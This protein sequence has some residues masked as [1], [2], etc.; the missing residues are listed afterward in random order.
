MANQR[1]GCPEIRLRRV[2]TEDLPGVVDAAHWDPVLVLDSIYDT[3][4][5]LIPIAPIPRHGQ[6]SDASLSWRHID[7][8]P[9]SAWPSA[10]LLARGGLSP[11]RPDDFHADARGAGARPGVG[12]AP[13]TDKEIRS[14][15][16]IELD[17]ATWVES[18]H[19]HIPDHVVKRLPH[20]S[21]DPLLRGLLAA[22]DQRHEF[23]VVVGETD[24][25]EPAAVTDTSAP[26]RLARGRIHIAL[27]DVPKEFV[28]NLAGLGVLWSVGAIPGPREVVAAVSSV[29]AV[30][31]FKTF[32]RLTADE[33]H[34]ANL[35]AEKASSGLSTTPVELEGIAGAD[36]L[37]LLAKLETDGIA[38][39]DNGCWKI[40]F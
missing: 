31:F 21:R 4:D 16:T 37:E 9:P 10:A 12:V 20:I 15:E 1:G 8:A 11:R 27:S 19:L 18:P 34:M 23:T 6:F 25:G 24:A 17:V 39:L 30:A 35:V 3:P 28:A 40:V 36:A 7:D 14:M 22:L 13:V 2:T 5:Y 29:G 33:A 32:S 38:A 26:L